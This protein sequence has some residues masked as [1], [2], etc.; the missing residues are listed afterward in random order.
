[1]ADKEEEGEWGRKKRMGKEEDNF[2][3]YVLNSV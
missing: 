1:M 2:Y 3:T